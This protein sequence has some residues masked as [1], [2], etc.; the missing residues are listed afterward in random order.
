MHLKMV[1]MVNLYCVHLA[2]A[3]KHTKRSWAGKGRKAPQDL[4]EAEERA[5]R[6]PREA[7]AGPC[8]GPGEGVP[9]VTETGLAEW[10]G[11]GSDWQ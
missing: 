3:L 10:W 11:Q 8:A 1:K 2:A 9:G 4:Q 5:R 6:S 7:T